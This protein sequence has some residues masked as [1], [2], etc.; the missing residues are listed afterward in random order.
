[1]TIKPGPT[2]H[3]RTAS[4]DPGDRQLC[5]DRPI[6]PTLRA[7]SY[8]EVSNPF[9]RLPLPTFFHQLEAVHLGD[10]LRLWVRPDVRMLW[11]E[12][13]DPSFGFSRV[14]NCAPNITKLQCFA[15]REAVSP[16]NAIPRSSALARLSKRGENSLWGNFQRVQNHL[17]VT[18]MNPHSGAGISTGFPFGFRRAMKSRSYSK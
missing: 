17:N 1:M 6:H 12:S 10:L 4:Q 8:P 18:V 11:L 5:T 3:P 7:N 16:L 9:C 13:P 15:N 2:G 14:I